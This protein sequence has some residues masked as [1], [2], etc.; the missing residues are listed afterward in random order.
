M[1]PAVWRQHLATA[2]WTVSAVYKH[3]L[4]LQSAPR[5]STTLGMT[6]PRALQ[7]SNNASSASLAGDQA[8]GT[9]NGNLAASPSNSNLS[10][11]DGASADGDDLSLESF[12][13]FLQH[14]LSGQHRSSS[15]SSATWSRGL[16]SHSLPDMDPKVCR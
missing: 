14:R 10:E 12:D 11:L 15:N 3:L 13:A 1:A 2:T 5:T 9:S 16:S 8:N 4:C 7:R 6:S